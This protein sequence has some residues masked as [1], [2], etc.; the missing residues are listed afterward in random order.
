MDSFFL[1]VMIN[2]VYW[3]GLLRIQ[4]T[5]NIIITTKAIVNRIAHRN[6][7][8]KKYV[9]INKSIH[10]IFKSFLPNI[11]AKEKDKRQY[12]VSYTAAILSLSWVFIF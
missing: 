11:N 10:N 9:A 12:I 4:F 2:H 6:D 7:P 5:N 8:V 3:K 1:C